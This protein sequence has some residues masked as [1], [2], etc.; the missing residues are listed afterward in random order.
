MIAT[1][2]G[3]FQSELGCP[4]DWDPGCLRSWLQDPDG[5][6]I[7]TF[8]TRALPPASYEAKVAI[9]ESWDE[10]Y[11]AGGVPS[12]ANI[13]FTVPAA[14]HG[15]VLLLR[16]G[17]A[18]ADRQRRRARPAATC[19]GRRPT[20]CRADTIAWNV[21]APA[22]GRLH[23]ARTRPTAACRSTTGG[24]AGGV[25]IPLDLDPG[26]PVRRRS[27]R[28]SR[29]SPA[30]RPSSC[31]R[32]V[33]PRC[34]RRSRGQLAVSAKDADGHAARRHGAADPRR[35]RRPLH[36]RRAARRRLVATACRRCG[37]GRPRPR[38]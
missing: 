34:R 3:S 10:N 23:A 5:D 27:W 9:N 18:R 28:A 36:L 19:A 33:W 37:C 6:G 7:Y 13:A 16:R 11:G 14:C 30:T 17:H 35:A 12:G 1:V 4:G 29:T 25:A 32:T 31:R 15:D 24:V 38:R 2:P 26:R 22:D 20:G 8:T 21:G